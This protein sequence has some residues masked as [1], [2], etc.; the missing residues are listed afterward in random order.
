MAERV[1]HPA[2]DRQAEAEACAG[3]VAVADAYATMELFEH[4]LMFI[5]RYAAAGVGDFDANH[6]TAPTGA[7]KHPAGARVT[8]R[9]RDDVLED[10][11]KHRAVGANH[12]LGGT[13]PE[14]Q[15]FLF[16][17]RLEIGF[18]RGEKLVESDPG[19]VGFH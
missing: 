11:P 6:R 8:H 17:E 3:N 19:D 13:E 2:H 18:D 9:V 4:R 1:G 5:L 12:G 15:T 7:D 16:S 14:F 10:T